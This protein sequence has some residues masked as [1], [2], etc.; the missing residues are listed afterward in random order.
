M[1]EPPPPFNFEAAH[2][3]LH[4][5]PLTDDTI[6]RVFRRAC[7]SGTY[8][9]LLLLTI[10]FWLLTR[11]NTKLAANPSAQPAENDYPDTSERVANIRK[12]ITRT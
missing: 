6:G 9:Q 1:S 3:H 11:S 5:V 4:R 7:E 12:K 10:D 2:N 8:E